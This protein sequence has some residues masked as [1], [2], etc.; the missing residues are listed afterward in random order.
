MATVFEVSCLLLVALLWG[1]TNPFL[2]K[3]TEGIEKVK[4][5]NFVTQLF[6]EIKFLFLNYKYLVPF[7]LNQSGSVIYYFTLAST[8]LSLAVLL[9]NSLTFLFTLLTGKLLGEEMGGK[10]A[11]T[12]MLLT[13]VGVTLCVA[14]TTS[15]ET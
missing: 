11:M 7:L 4:S 14:S 10:Q 8:D 15:M 12:G 13:I 5:R 6:A 3:G 2:K 1:G 9:S